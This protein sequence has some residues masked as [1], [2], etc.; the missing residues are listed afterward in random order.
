MLA[1]YFSSKTSYRSSI[2]GVS[3]TVGDEKVADLIFFLEFQLFPLSGVKMESNSIN[4]DV[5]FW[6]LDAKTHNKD[7]LIGHTF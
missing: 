3:D 1:V 7:S 4:G 5:S 2:E 6:I